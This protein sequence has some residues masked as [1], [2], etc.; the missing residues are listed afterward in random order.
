MPIISDN[1]ISPELS[2]KFT[3]YY[4]KNNKE[5]YSGDRVVTENLDNNEYDI[6]HRNDYGIADV[7]YDN[8]GVRFCGDDGYCWSFDDEDSVHSLKF[9][10]VI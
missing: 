5:I 7:I 6:W 4:D 2:D 9:I 10:E 3:E 8:E 1:F